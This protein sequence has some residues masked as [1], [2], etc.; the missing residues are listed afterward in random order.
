MILYI[1]NEYCYTI[2]QLRSYFT[3]GLV[4]GSNAYDDLLDYGRHG[5]LSSWLREI[6]ESSI[7]ESIDSIDSG[8]TDS[9]YM[10]KLGSAITGDVVPAPD[11]PAFDK[12]F[13]IEDVS[14]KI[15]ESEAMFTLT[16]RVLL[17]VNENYIIKAVS[18]W[19][20]KGERIN[21][22]NYAERS[23]L[24]QPFTFRKRAGK[25]LGEISLYADEVQLSLPS[26]STGSKDSP[27][28]EFT[29]GAV[30][31]KM[32]H[33]EGGSFMMGSPDNDS[34]AYSDEQPQ[35]RVTLSDYYIG[36]TQVTQELW[37]A[38]MGDNPSNWK[39][40]SL[41]VEEVSWEDC[42]EF[43]KQ[44]NLKTGKTF[45]LPTE[46]EW[47]YAAR[48]G[49]K[50]LGYKYAGGNDIDKVAWYWNNSGGKTHPVKQKSANELGLYD[51]SGNVWE[52]C[53]DWWGRYSIDTQNNPKG[54]TSGSYRVLRGGSWD[55][56]ARG[57][58]LAYRNCGSPDY[59]RNVCGFRLALVHQ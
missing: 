36:E 27:Y 38:V 52:W 29:V 10:S 33:V 42:Q 6:G 5:D 59:R 28:R 49:R 35:H 54:P 26:L 32:I 16:L 15:A 44:L 46:A 13:Q 43:I 1:D 8:L 57:C 48:G 58:R 2:S 4:V 47:E 20:I 17:S 53:Q 19:G 14:T 41:P 55:G 12:C 22:S 18:G 39:G 7:A 56:S 30:Q 31:F 9:E 11:K 45:R 21:P 50:S 25:T 23:I 24:Q 40:D 51:M 34:D 37:K 3:K